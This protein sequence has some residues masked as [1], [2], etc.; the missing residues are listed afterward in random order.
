MLSKDLLVFVLSSFVLAALAD[1]WF[2]LARDGVADLALPLLLLLYG[3]LRMY[4]PTA[5]AL[6]ALKLSGKGLREE[7]ASYL[8]IRG[9]AVLHYLAAPLLVYFALGVYTLLGLATGLVDL[10][11]PEKVLLEQLSRQGSFPVTAELLRALMLA[12]LLL[13]Y[14]PAVTLNAFFALGEEIGWRGYMYRRLGSQPDLKSITVIGTT[15]GLWHATA[16]G[17]LGHNY[18]VL[19][20]AGVPLFIPFCILLTAI[21]LPL[22]TRAQSILPA[23]SLH[24]AL[25]ALWSFTILATRLEGIEGEVLGGLGALGLLSLAVVYLVLR[26]FFNR[27]ARRG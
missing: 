20:W 9:R 21:M 8:S 24:G 14:I 1:A 13:A 3:L 2:Y 4:T 16:I 7:L 26:V 12:Q 18:P 17:L 23:V 25:N 19:R 22:V 11:K 10:G 5:G 27:L 6:L 15:W